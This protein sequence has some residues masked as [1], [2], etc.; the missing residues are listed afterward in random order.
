MEADRSELATP[1]V[2]GWRAAALVALALAVCAID[3]W[4][5][6]DVP[7]APWGWW[8]IA[9][10]ELQIDLWMSGFRVLLALATVAL[11]TRLGVPGRAFA[12]FRRPRQ[13][14]AY[15]VRTTVVISAIA[16]V[17]IGIAAAVFHLLDVGTLAV[18]PYSDDPSYL[19][20]SFVLAPVFEELIYRLVLVTM[21]AAAAGRWPALLVSTVVFAASHLP[22]VSPS[23][24]AAGALLGWAYL[25]SGTLVVP[26]AL[27][28]AGNVFVWLLSA[29]LR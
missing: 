15:W 22:G 1:S 4:I 16:S 10:T 19:V 14:I 7:G 17:C 28:A 20:G 11:A 27:H 9:R 18:Q 13:P 2:R 26:I 8:H 3:Q 6:R 25:R 5:L 29:A 12:L 21:V 23:H 24:V